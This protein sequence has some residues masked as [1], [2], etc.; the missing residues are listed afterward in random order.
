MEDHLKTFLYELLRLVKR[1]GIVPKIDI[2]V[3][4]MHMSKIGL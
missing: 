4:L 3:N 2:K 1:V